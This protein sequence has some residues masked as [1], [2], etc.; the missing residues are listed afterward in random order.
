[1]RRFALAVLIPALFVAGCGLEFVTSS[2]NGAWMWGG[3]AGTPLYQMTPTRVGT[4]GGIEMVSVGTDHAVALLENGSVYTM[5]RN[6]RGQL[7]NGTTTDNA[8]PQKVGLPRG[9]RKV[10]AGDGFS[11][12][13][14]TD[15]S[16]YIWGKKDI[17]QDPRDNEPVCKNPE[18]SEGLPLAAADIAAGTSHA[19][20]LLTDGRVFGW[21]ANLYGQL[22]NGTRNGGPTPVEVQRLTGAVKAIAAG[23]A[24]S[25]ALLTDGMVVAWGD[26]SRYQLGNGSRPAS[27]FPNFVMEGNTTTKVSGIT[28][29]DADGDNT[30]AIRTG[31]K[32]VAW[33]GNFV[34]DL[35]YSGGAVELQTLPDVLEVSTGYSHSLALVNNGGKREVWGWGSGNV[36]GDG[37]NRQ[38]MAPTQVTGVKDPSGVSA[39]AD[40]SVVLQIVE[41]T[42][43]VQNGGNP[44]N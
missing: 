13:L 27:L 10:A 20:V 17:C 19:V 32:C 8:T 25:V 2:S 9:A 26:D 31:K 30:V 11:M 37:V 40:F 22:G 39:G 5:G 41:A 38:R 12:A 34:G 24:H 6:D 33:G 23:R 16:V 1:M 14:L 3:T 21:G 18:K 15:G 7:G 28:S 4:V 44:V 29:I 43:G 35:G 36:L 42:V